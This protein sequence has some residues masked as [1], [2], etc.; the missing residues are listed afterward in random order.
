[1]TT[2]AISTLPHHHGG[3]RRCHYHSHPHD[4]FSTTSI[5]PS[6]YPP[7]GSQQPPRQHHRVTFTTPLTPPSSPSLTRHTTTAI[8]T[9][10]HL[11]LH[12]SRRPQLATDT[13]TT[14]ILV[15]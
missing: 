8:P 3:G 14:S 12:L 6:P 7:Q 10:R 2:V 9:N 11:H 13:T 15:L 5:S 1:A 4:S